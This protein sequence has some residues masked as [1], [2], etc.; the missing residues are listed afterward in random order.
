MSHPGRLPLQQRH[1]LGDILQPPPGH[2]EADEGLYLDL[3]GGVQGEDLAED[4]AHYISASEVKR[5]DG[6]EPWRGLARVEA[7]T[8]Q[9]VLGVG[10]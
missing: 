3:L 5:A 8:V 7:A 6:T 10:E 2:P 9:Q 4:L 1:Q